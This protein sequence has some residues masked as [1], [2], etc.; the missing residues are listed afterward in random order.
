MSE[1]ETIL[2]HELLLLIQKCTPEDK[3]SPLALYLPGY[4]SLRLLLIQPSR[5]SREDELLKAV[6]ASYASYKKGGH[7]SDSDIASMTARDFMLLS[8]LNNNVL[9]RQ[10]SAEPVGAQLQIQQHQPQHHSHDSD[11]LLAATLINLQRQSGG[12]FNGGGTIN[13]HDS[14]FVGQRHA[15]ATEGGSDVNVDNAMQQ[16]ATGNQFEGHDFRS[17]SPTISPALHPIFTSQE[18]FA[19]LGASPT[20]HPITS[21]HDGISGIAPLGF[22]ATQLSAMLQNESFRGL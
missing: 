4:T 16:F 9:P 5:S 20:F 21:D 14:L 17:T 8:K 11:P 1:E 2:H 18:Q 22:T 3:T 15:N 12:P 19:G 7:R 13:A 6:L 10:E